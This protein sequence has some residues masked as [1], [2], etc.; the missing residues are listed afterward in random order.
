MKKTDFPLENSLNGW[1]TFHLINP[2]LLNFRG[3]QISTLKLMLGNILVH[4]ISLQ[5]FSQNNFLEAKRP[6]LNNSLK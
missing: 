2:L 5:Q 1:I 6:F 3:F 4:N